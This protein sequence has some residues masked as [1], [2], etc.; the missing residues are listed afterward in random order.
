MILFVMIECSIRLLFL[1]L[2]TDKRASQ[3]LAGSTGRS[4]AFDG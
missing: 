2:L 1:S 3:W 4:S